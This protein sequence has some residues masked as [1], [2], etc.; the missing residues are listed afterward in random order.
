VILKQLKKFLSI[1]FALYVAN[2]DVRKYRGTPC[3]GFQMTNRF[4]G[5]SKTLVNTT[6]FNG[7]CIG[8]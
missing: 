2:M 7:F 3:I 1:E 8:K 6:G 4:F 5:C